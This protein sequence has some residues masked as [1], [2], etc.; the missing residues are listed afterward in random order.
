MAIEIKNKTNIEKI[1]NCGLILAAVQKLLIKS[2]RP[3][4]ST[5]ELDQIAEDYTLSKGFLPAFK[6]YQE[7]PANIC[8]SIND[9]VVHGVPSEKRI[10]NEGD[11]V[12]ILVFLRTNFMP[13]PLLLFP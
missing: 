3:G 4:I 9:E 13:M 7:F 5:L 1:K 12:G 11:I 2:I 6:G 10:L 8:A